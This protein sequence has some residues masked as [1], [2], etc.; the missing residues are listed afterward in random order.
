MVLIK[1]IIYF[2]VL[3]IILLI[4]TP[5]GYYTYLPSF[6]P[7]YPNNMSDL[8]AVVESRRNIT[9][10]LMQFHKRTDKSVIFGF[11][12]YFQSQGINVSLKELQDISNA[13][14]VIMTIYLLKLIHNRRRPYQY[15]PGLNLVSHT[16]ATPSYPAGHAYQAFEL[17]KHFGNKY[18]DHKERLVKLAEKCDYVRVAAGLH[19]PTDGKYSRWLVGDI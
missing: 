14:N 4:V 6:I 15:V 11:Y 2:V 7:T 18:P 5:H 13:P 12:D 16:A 17:A 9:P 10:E 19:Y 1:A 3:Y 8:E